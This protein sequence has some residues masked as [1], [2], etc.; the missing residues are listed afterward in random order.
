[1]WAAVPGRGGKSQ[2]EKLPAGTET[3]NRA[4]TSEAR[5]QSKKRCLHVSVEGQAAHTSEGAQFLKKRLDRVLSLS[6]S[7][8]Y[9]KIRNLTGKRRPQEVQ[10]DT[11]VSCRA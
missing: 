5:E 4:H 7:A 2:K 8:R 10:D 1:M 6:M 3:P 9:E 11:F